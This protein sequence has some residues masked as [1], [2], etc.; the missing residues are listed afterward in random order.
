MAERYTTEDGTTTVVEQRRGPGTII[1]VIAVAALVIVGLLFATGFW[2]ADMQ[3]GSLP[4]VDV[5]AKGGSLPQVDLKS[6]ELVVGTKTTTV[7]VPKVETK[8]AHIEVPVVG[9]KDNN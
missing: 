7:D 5:S 8:K 2:K 6:K 9:V 1:A 4:K 3:G